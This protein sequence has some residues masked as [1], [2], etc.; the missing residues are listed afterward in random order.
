MNKQKISQMENK[1][2]A[3]EAFKKKSG[4]TTPKSEKK[5]ERRPDPVIELPVTMKADG[6]YSSHPEQQ[7]SNVGVSLGPIVVAK[8]KL[9]QK[10]PMFGNKSSS[11]KSENKEQKHERP[12]REYRKVPDSVLNDPHYDLGS[13]SYSETEEEQFK[14]GKRTPKKLIVGGSPDSSASSKAK[15]NKQAAKEKAKLKLQVQASVTKQWDQFTSLSIGNA[16]E[17]EFYTKLVHEGWNSLTPEVQVDRADEWAKKKIHETF[18]EHLWKSA[19]SEL[20]TE[21]AALVAQ[22]RL[23]LLGQIV[24]TRLD[25]KHKITAKIVK[26]VRDC[27]E[28][29]VEVD[30]VPKFMPEAVVSVLRSQCG[31]FVEQCGNPTAITFYAA[32]NWGFL[33]ELVKEVDFDKG[34]ASPVRKPGDKMKFTALNRKKRA[35]SVTL[36]LALHKAYPGLTP[37]NVDAICKTPKLLCSNELLSQI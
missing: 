33:Y 17:R 25:D 4:K 26:I 15:L 9:M 14:A 32:I 10:G 19:E 34:P 12:Q 16:F 24:Q 1:I 21:V 2:K 11:F 5:I 18:E 3:E 35:T 23:K 27:L 13:S 30:K 36:A 20:P 28:E 29:I 22:D 7:P 8:K 6:T 31:W 37:E